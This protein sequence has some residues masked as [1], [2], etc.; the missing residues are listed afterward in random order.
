MGLYY[1]DSNNQ[2][3]YQN[4]QE[5]KLLVP[6][7]KQATIESIRRNLMAINCFVESGVRHYR[8]IQSEIFEERSFII[9]G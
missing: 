1:N 2:L 4:E 8:G 5:S 3:I 6:F 9:K 7:S